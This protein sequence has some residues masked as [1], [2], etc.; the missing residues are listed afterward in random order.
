MA[1]LNAPVIQEL[2][3]TLL[4]KNWEGFQAFA[5]ENQ[6]LCVCDRATRRNPNEGGYEKA[7]AEKGMR[8]RAYVCRVL[9]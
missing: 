8:E 7:S 5:K 9:K 2:I 1:D 6:I 3:P 4:G